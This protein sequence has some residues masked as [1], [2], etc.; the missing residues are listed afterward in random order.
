MLL[1][2]GDGIAAVVGSYWLGSRAHPLPYNR[3]KSV[4]GTMA[5]IVASIAASLVYI[6][7]FE[8]YHFFV[9]ELAPS[10]LLLRLVVVC[11]VC[12]VVESGT[13][14]L[15]DNVIVFIVASMMSTVLLASS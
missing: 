4:E 2:V 9:V 14:T 7:L 3:K 1:C 12:G 6:R 8:S 10:A 11:T 13:N 5:F 15:W